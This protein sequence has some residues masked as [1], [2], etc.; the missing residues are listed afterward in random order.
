MSNKNQIMQP[1]LPYAENA[2]EPGEH[3]KN[4]KTVCIVTSSGDV[5]KWHGTC[6]I[7]KL[8]SSSETVH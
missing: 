5:V 4:P 2:L 8:I 3:T 1:D 6:R 7:I